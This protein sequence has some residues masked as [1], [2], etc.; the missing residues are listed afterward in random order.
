MKGGWVEF[1]T[2]ILNRVPANFGFELMFGEA[3]S[4]MFL[5][6]AGGVAMCPVVPD[7][8]RILVYGIHACILGTS[9]HQIVSSK[10]I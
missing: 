9:K 6:G 8:V 4:N 2:G 10:R 3:I 1:A 7:G 5:G